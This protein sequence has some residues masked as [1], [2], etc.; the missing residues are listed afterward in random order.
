M[1]SIPCPGCNR[2]FTHAG[3][4][5]HLSMTACRSCRAL[6]SGDLD[7]S[8]VNHSFG[9]S[10]PGHNDLHGNVGSDNGNA[11]EYPC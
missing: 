9:V 7:R 6:Y 5:R 3:Y 2:H 4:S 10:S 8:V 1:S 11:G